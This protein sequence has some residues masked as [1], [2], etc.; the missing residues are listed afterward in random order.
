LRAGCMRTL[1]ASNEERLTLVEVNAA[2]GPV[3]LVEAVNEGTHAVVPELNH[4]RVQGRQD[5][6][7]LRV[8]AQPLHLLGGRHITKG[9]W[10]GCQLRELQQKEV[11]LKAVEV[12]ESLPRRLSLGRESFPEGL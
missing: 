5:P 1:T 4:S 10:R 9:G 3:V 12:Q 7:P 6:W 8:E 11:R 2:H